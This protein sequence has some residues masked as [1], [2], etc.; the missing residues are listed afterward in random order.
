MAGLLVSTVSF[1]SVE[2]QA[3]VKHDKAAARREILKL[4]DALNR[5]DVTAFRAVG[6][7]VVKRGN[8]TLTATEVEAMV[9]GFLPSRSR[10]DARPAKLTTFVRN[11]GAP[12]RAI[13]VVTFEVWDYSEVEDCMQDSHG[14]DFCSGA[15]WHKGFS[16]WTAEFDGPQLSTLTERHTIF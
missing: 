14:N 2:A 3:R 16:L 11:T 7:F 6:Q 15:G 10:P 5:G 12:D 8:A 4:L 13:Y 1:S 9:R